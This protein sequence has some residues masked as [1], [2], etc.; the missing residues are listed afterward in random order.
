VGQEIVPG[1]NLPRAA[2]ILGE[3]CPEA[4]NTLHRT[5]TPKCY[6]RFALAGP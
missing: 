4:E 6:R 1:M 5:T 3:I 2:R